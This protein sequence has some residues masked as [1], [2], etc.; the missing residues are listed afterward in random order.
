MSRKRK[1]KEN[2]VNNIVRAPRL[3]VIG[4][5]GCGIEAVTMMME[6]GL[7]GVDF[8]AAD[9]DGHAL[10][11]S[12]V[13]DRVQLGIKFTKGLCA[14]GGESDTAS[15]AAVE[16]RDALK[17][18]LSGADMIFIV[19]GLGGRTGAVADP[20]VAEAAK[21]TGALVV[22]VAAMPFSVESNA[23]KG[24]S[25]LI[26]L[27]DTVITIPCQS[28]L[29]DVDETL[30]YTDA[31]KGAVEALYLAVKGI[32]DMLTC[33]SFMGVGFAD[34]HAVISEARQGVMGTGAAKGDNRVQEA[35]RRALSSPLLGDTT[36]HGA[37]RVI[38]NITGAS[39]NVDTAALNEALDILINELHEGADVLHTFVVDDS[40][41]EEVRVTVIAAGFVEDEG[42]GHTQVSQL[43]L[44]EKLKKG[45]E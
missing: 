14:G 42:S 4:V 32:S 3:K 16:S 26:K 44:M 18:A 27:A 17:K 23:V 43:K 19:A 5:G 12:K 45:A 35:V 20:V 7:R 10:E 8:L 30:P 13:N 15:N 1:K 40:M 24:L 33:A 36:L 38:M 41:G 6:R 21:G 9:T 39:C 31:Y 34:V 22:A 29:T 28:L 25:R 11:R 2:N 37:K